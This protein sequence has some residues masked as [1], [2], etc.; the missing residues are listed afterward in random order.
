M[1]TFRALQGLAGGTIIPLSLTGIM[2]LLNKEQ[3]PVGMSLFAIAATCAPTIGPAL[4]GWLAESYGWQW[5]FFINLFPAILLLFVI[6]HCIPSSSR[7]KAAINFSDWAGLLLLLPALAALEVFLEEGNSHH[8]FN[9]EWIV[10]AAIVASTGL[11][12]FCITQIQ[13]TKPLINI[14]LLSHSELMFAYCSILGLGMALYGSIFLITQYHAQVHGFS[15]LQIAKILLWMGIPQI[16]IL[17]FMPKLTTR[18][19]PKISVIFGFLLFLTGT[20]FSTPPTVDFAG[21]YFYVNQLIRAA[22][23]PFIF[24]PLSLLVT[25]HLSSEDI[26]SA[27]IMVDIALAI[28]GALGIALLSI[29]IER[30][31]SLHFNEMS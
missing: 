13:S 25:K 26:P 30:K 15:T 6:Q 29:I 28:G 8:W 1:V 27:S 14:K 17:P 21:E 19:P 20:L 10:A 18:I 9:T 22:G 7:F 3:R 5:I 4:G 16:L 24:V 2:T 23:Q 31:T 12:G 11:I